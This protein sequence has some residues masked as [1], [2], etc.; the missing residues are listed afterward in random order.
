MTDNY[1]LCRKDREGRRRGD[2]VALQLK[3]QLGCVVLLR[4]GQQPGLRACESGPEMSVK[5][6][7]R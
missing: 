4:D 3:E 2:A 7:S 6:A 5:V 1:R